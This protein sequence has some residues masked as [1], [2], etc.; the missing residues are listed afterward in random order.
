MPLTTGTTLNNRYRIV[1]LLGQGG[2]GAVYRVWD[3]NMECPRALKENLETSP[4][5]QR[6]FKLEAQLLD[7]LSHPHLPR[8]IDH[9]I[10]PGQGQYLV[11]DFVEG[12]DLQQRLERAGAPLTESEVLPWIEQVCDALS[13]L[14]RQNPPVIHRDIKPANIRITLEGKALLVDFGIAKLYDPHAPTTL[15][16]RAATPGYSPLEQYGRG[17]HT[18]ARSD[19]YALGAT[20]YTL[21][22]GQV[23]P[24]APERVL[25]EALPP[26]RQLNPALSPRLEQVILKALA[27]QPQDRFQSAAEFKQALRAAG[28]QPV[29][30]MSKTRTVLVSSLPPAAPTG[31]QSTVRRIKWG[32][33][34]AASAGALIGLLLIGWA[35]L[36]IIPPPTPTLEHGSSWVEWTQTALARM[37]G[38]MATQR[39]QEAE[40]TTQAAISPTLTPLDTLESLPFITDEHGVRMALIPAGEFQM[41][42]NADDS[43]AECRKFRSDC[44]RDWFT[45]EEPVHGVYLDAFYMDIYE[46]TNALFAEF[47]NARGNQKE[48]GATWLDAG[49]EDARIHRAGGR[50]Q[51][52][53]GYEDHPAVGVTWYGARAFCEWRGARLPTEAE[54]EKAARGGVTGANYP[55][56]DEAPVCEKGAQNGAQ[57]GACDG[58]TVAVGSFAANGYGLFD[59]AGNVW[60]W[61][62]D[63]YAADYYGG[64]RLPN[65][66]GPD[67]GEGRVVRGGSWRLYGYNLRSAYRYSYPPS[68]FINSN[69]FR[70]ARSK[71]NSQP[72]G[73]HPPIPTT[74]ETASWKQGKLAYV[75]K[76]NVGTS[77]NV[78]DL[79]LD[80]QP[81]PIFED[82]GRILAPAW[83]PDGVNITFHLLGGDLLM[84]K[85]APGL[86]LEWHNSNC[87]GASWSPDGKRLICSSSNNYYLILS[88][89]SGIEINRVSTSYRLYTL[90]WSPSVDEFAYAVKD[91]EITRIERMQLGGNAPTI[92]ADAASENYAPSYSP[93]G[94]WIAYQSN[95]GSSL[96]EIWVMTREGNNPRR[97]TFTSPGAWSRA[98]SWSP[99][100]KWLAYVSNQV[101]SA[102]PDFGEIFLVSL[103]TDDVFQLT[104]TNG[105]VYDWRVTWGK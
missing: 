48:G 41:G 78:L 69:G 79:T 46:V 99:D 14:H 38:T 74:T 63:W 94:Q 73:T 105:N 42:G 8:V 7:K 75:L 68:Y 6:Q 49:D 82:S 47:L 95:K 44:Q 90:S 55:W 84:I 27:M 21:L 2:F 12:E 83:S 61:V 64:P 39:T 57:F 60:E 22:T 30:P 58:E 43:L 50:W 53:A 86:N 18:D 11:M 20:L 81:V 93:D 10:L 77:L 24:E 31:V 96:S 102:G 1:R 37:N 85:A 70:C 13:Y 72:N 51:A 56:G 28:T 54:W 59:M 87:T 62:W 9:F 76:S 52:D 35:L 36:R 17:A 3:L 80:S 92:L 19:V 71:G 89:D 25:G 5:A 34:G 29:Q 65:P 104:F 98:P 101:D 100:G 26:P 103:E 23:P 67:S 32:I 16:A 88:S 45:D 4:E 40:Q 91:G 15:G 97:V 33:W 66:R